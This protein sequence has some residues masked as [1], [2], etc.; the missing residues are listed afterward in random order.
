MST[1][2]RGLAETH[3]SKTSPNKTTSYDG[4]VFF[5]QVLDVVK[6][7]ET[8]GGTTVDSTP[9]LV[10]A[11]R[12]SKATSKKKPESQ[13]NNVAVPLDR[14]SYRLPMPGEQVL[15]M[16]QLDTY[17]YFAV[18]SSLTS[19]TVNIDP[20]M[21]LDAFESNDGP[22]I[23]ADPSIEKERFAGRSD[24]DQATVYGSSSLFSRV[25]E[26]ETIME[27]RMGGVI[28]LTH[29]IT[30]EGVWNAEKQ[31]ANL[32]QSDDGD[33]MLVMKSNVRRKKLEDV[34][35]VSNAL[36]DDD[37]NE[38]ASSFYLTSTQVIPMQIATSVSMSSWSV[39]L[40]NL[41]SQTAADDSN[42]LQSLFPDRF[43]PNDTVSVNVSGFNLQQ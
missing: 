38:D 7:G 6:D 5:A 2:F 37:I 22:A 41:D 1:L 39:E 4:E 35:F 23:T 8:V 32:G 19:M 43:N 28:K 18:V 25:R 33:P 13:A 34:G 36:E 10:G 27:G 42:S 26:G 12:F 21:F 40:S 20:N 16:R 15:V 3:R 24:F 14:A 31:I 30:K 29:T 9:Q 11:I 17:Y